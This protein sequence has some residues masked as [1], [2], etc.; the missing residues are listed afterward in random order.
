LSAFILSEDEMIGGGLLLQI[1]FL[2]DDRWRV[3][4]TKVDAVP[5]SMKAWIDSQP[6]MGKDPKLIVSID[7]MVEVDWKVALISAVPQGF[8]PLVKLLKFDVQ[9]PSGPHSS[10][11]KKR[12]L[13][14]EESPPQESYS[15]AT[16]ENEGESISAPVK[17]VD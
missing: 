9:L 4:M 10:T 2:I 1:D 8:N 5:N 16:I 11:V 12:T 15:D 14:Y 6:G 7:V 3:T 17:K 13:R